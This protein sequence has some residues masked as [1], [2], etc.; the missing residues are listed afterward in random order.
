MLLLGDIA[1]RH[2]ALRGDKTAYVIGA[3]RVT[4][5]TLHARSNQ[6]A[7]GLARLGVRHGDRVAVMASNRTEYPIIYFAIIKLGAIVVPINARFTAAEVGAVVGHCEAETCF[8]AG[9]FAAL[10]ADVRASGQVPLLRRII[11]IDADPAFPMRHSSTRSQ[12]PNRPTTSASPSTSTT[13]T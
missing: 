8:I 12:T 6:L 10:L 13:R 4:Y 9:E 5:R 2:A 3:A 11:A 7:R 1:R